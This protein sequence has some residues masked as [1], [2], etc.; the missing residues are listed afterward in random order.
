LETDLPASGAGADSGLPGYEST[1]WLALY[2]PAKT[3]REIV[4]KL[5]EAV[6][7]IMVSS[8]VQERYAKQRM[9]AVSST[10]EHLIEYIQAEL[11]KWGKVVKEADIKPE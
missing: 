7:R 1:I 3:P 11:L 4:T 9:A 10:P 2:A 8:D 5:N 6:A